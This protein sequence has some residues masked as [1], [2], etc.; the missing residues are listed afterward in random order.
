VS[1]IIDIYFTPYFSANLVFCFLASTFLVSGI[2]GF[3]IKM[4]MLF[5][6]L[7]DTYYKKLGPV[8]GFYHDGIMGL[9]LQ[10]ILLIFLHINAQYG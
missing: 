10:F 3:P 9:I 5:S 6:H 4:S 2:V 8:R 7:N 1:Q